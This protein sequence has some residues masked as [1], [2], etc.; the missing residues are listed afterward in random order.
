M[1]SPRE[2]V[3]SEEAD[4]FVRAELQSEEK[5]SFES[6]IFDQPKVLATRKYFLI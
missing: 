6:G 1:K 4:Y 2:I 3:S 5:T